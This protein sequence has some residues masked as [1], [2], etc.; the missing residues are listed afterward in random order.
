MRASI[1]SSPLPIIRTRKFLS[2]GWTIN[3]GQYVKMAMQLNDL[4]LKD[5]KVLEDQ[6]TGVD[7]AYFMQLIDAL[8]DVEPEKMNAAYISTI[9]DRIF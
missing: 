3:A 7:A 4:D 2:R 9:I 5:V 1:Q 8:K 6:L